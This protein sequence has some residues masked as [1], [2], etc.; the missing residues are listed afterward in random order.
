MSAED[1]SADRSASRL[2]YSTGRWDG[3]TLVVETSAVNYG[4]FDTVGIPLGSAATI[5]EQFIPSEDGKSLD[6]KMTVT[7]AATF[8]EP[9]ELS[10]RWLALPGASVQPYECDQ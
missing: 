8:T 6:F 7:D 3:S 2:G 1:T 5:T 4:H 10:K 9:V